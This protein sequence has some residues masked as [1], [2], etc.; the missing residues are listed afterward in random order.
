MSTIGVVGGGIA[1]LSAAYHLQREGVSVHVLEA[2]DHV[3]G[4]IQTEE[5]EGFV[6]EHGP[7]SLRSTPLLEE[8]IAR[9]DLESERVWA[10]ES[11]SRRYVVRNGRPVALPTSFFSFLRTNLFSTRAKIRLLAEPFIRARSS[12]VTEE[13]LAAFTTRRL[14]PE[15]L[16]YA[17]APFVGGVFAGD[18]DQLSARHAFERLVTLEEEHG[19][20]LWGAIAGA[21]TSSSGQNHPSSLFSFRDGL[22]TLPRALH[23]ALGDA[24]THSTTVRRIHQTGNQWEVEVENDVSGPFSFDALV[25]TIPLH[26]IT[27]IE[28]D[29]DGNLDPLEGVWYPPLHVIALGYDRSTVD[30]PIDGFGMLVPPVEDEFDILG[31]LFSSTLFPNRAP[32]GQVLLTTFVGG[33]RDPEIAN[34]PQSHVRKTI[35]ERDL[36]RLLGISGPPTFVHGCHWPRAIPQYTLG[37]GQVKTAL[38]DVEARNPNLVFAGNYRNGVSVGAAMQSGAD[39]ASELLNE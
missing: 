29:V 30:H 4:V 36:S 34:A 12:E 33:A 31:T 9:L 21:S 22:E 27:N 18:P 37:Y 17:V 32:D 11:A 38:N 25:C 35:V 28:F 26:E 3:G 5:T 13:S 8:M 39:A 10:D 2:T 14:G 6:V 19:S 23:D 24:V 7:N 15:I 20:L 1:G 16:D